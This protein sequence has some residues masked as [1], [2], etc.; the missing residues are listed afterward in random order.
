MFQ[1]VFMKF[2]NLAAPVCFAIALTACGDD[3]SSSP[4]V[5][6]N[7]LPS[8]DTSAVT[9]VVNPD[10]PTG[11]QDSVPQ[12]TDPQNTTPQDTVTQTS[13][14]P[15]P[16]DSVP[17]T[18]TD[19]VP[20]TPVETDPYAVGKDIDE[21]SYVSTCKVTPLENG[22]GDGV[23]CDTTYAGPIF[24]DTD[25]T[26]YDP[27]ADNG[28][29]FVSINKV[30]ESLKADDK[31]VFVLRHADR[32]TS[33]GK[34]SHLTDVGVFQAQSVG[35][36]IAS[37]EPAYYAHSEYVRTR[38]TLENIAVGRGET[39]FTHDA[40]P[41]LNGSWYIKDNAKYDEYKSQ[42]T[43]MNYTVTTEWAYNGEYA[44]AFYDLDERTKQF[45]DEFLV[46]VIS[47]KSRISVVC[48]HDQFLVPLVISISKRQI[49]LRY[50][51][52]RS[53]INYLAGMAVVIGADGSQTLVPIKGLNSGA[54]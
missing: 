12:N 34:T 10:N 22:T 8:Q 11:T 44:D 30:F 2:L 18:P 33:A 52:D 41:I 27:A 53:W 14:D 16:T 47:K 49:G 6:A 46:N 36:K 26:A 45:V 19:S 15:A 31:V 20:T 21:P 35:K 3:S 23:Y 24:Y 38:E 43:D 50:H 32:Q 37:A 51:E 1:E 29:S 25:E 48:S 9:P 39:D 54:N 40:Y 42:G 4:N 7:N 13:T 17:S 28:A 5:P